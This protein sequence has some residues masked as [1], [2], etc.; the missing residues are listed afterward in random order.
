MHPFEGHVGE[1]KKKINMLCKKNSKIS[2]K[3][4]KKV[5]T[6]KA[7]PPKDTKRVY[8]EAREKENATPAT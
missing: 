7:K 8:T 1:G 5:N 3:K 6:V 4:K 2:K